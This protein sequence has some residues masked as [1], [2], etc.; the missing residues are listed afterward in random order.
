MVEEEHE[1]VI[2]GHY[3][4]LLKQMIA[5]IGDDLTK[6]TFIVWHE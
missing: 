4:D 1:R 3:T 6:S 2:T 5:D